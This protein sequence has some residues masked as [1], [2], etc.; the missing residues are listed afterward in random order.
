MLPGTSYNDSWLM[1]MEALR[2]NHSGQRKM[3]PNY[4]RYRFLQIVHSFKRCYYEKSFP[5][6]DLAP[7]RARMNLLEKLIYGI[8]MPTGFSL[9]RAIP[10][11]LRSGL[12]SSLRRL[13]GQHAIANEAATERHFTNLVQV[14]ESMDSRTDMASS[15]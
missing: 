2:V 1:A 4:R 10:T 7:L 5:A 8:G 15:H 13:I 14:F 6:A 9:M 11:G 12:I 3:L